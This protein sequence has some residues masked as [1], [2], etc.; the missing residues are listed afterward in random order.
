MK[1]V[2]SGV[3]H[4]KHPVFPFRIWRCVVEELVEYRV[5]GFW[6]G[7][8]AYSAVVILNWPCHLTRLL[9]VIIEERV[10][11]DDPRD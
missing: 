6:V 1:P 2:A 4:S 7:L 5:D 10:E 3:T 8:R 9:V 11:E